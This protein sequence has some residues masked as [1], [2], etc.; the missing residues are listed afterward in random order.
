[1]DIHT[2]AYT[3][4]KYCGTAL[5]GQPWNQGHPQQDAARAPQC[6]CVVEAGTVPLTLIAAVHHLLQPKLSRLKAMRYEVLLHLA[7]QS[8]GPLEMG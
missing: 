8:Y 3:C 6:E 5:E 7:L 4:E 2:Q 1:M